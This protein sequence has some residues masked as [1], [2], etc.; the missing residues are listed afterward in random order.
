MLCVPCLPVCPLGAPPG[1]GFGPLCPSQSP[2]ELSG[3]GLHRASCSGCLSSVLEGSLWL[4][5]KYRLGP[6]LSGLFLRRFCYREPRHPCCTAVLLCRLLGF[7]NRLPDE[8]TGEFFS[9]EMLKRR[10][11]LWLKAFKDVCLNVQKFYFVLLPTVLTSRIASFL[12]CPVYL[13]LVVFH[14]LQHTP[15]SPANCSCLDLVAVGLCG[16]FHLLTLVQ[17]ACSPGGCGIWGGKLA[18]REACLGVRG[19][20]TDTPELQG[21]QGQEQPETDSYADFLAL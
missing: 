8:A 4:S 10:F 2:R 1:L 14:Q 17:R 20:E 12:V 13:L 16:E 3:S 11:D 9:S 18:F 7:P 21:F 5:L 15:W 19:W 6:L